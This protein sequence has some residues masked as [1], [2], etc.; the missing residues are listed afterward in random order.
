[1]NGAGPPSKK[2]NTAWR[3]ACWQGMGERAQWGQGAIAKKREKEV[4]TIN[5]LDRIASLWLRRWPLHL[6]MIII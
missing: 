4:Q 6:G 5:L 3:L 2:K 1:M